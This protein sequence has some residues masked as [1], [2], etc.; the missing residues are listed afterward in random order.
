MGYWKVTIPYGSY[1]YVKN[2]IAMGSA[3]YASIGAGITITLDTARSYLGY[4]N[5]K[6][7]GSNDNTGIS[8]TLQA[9]AAVGHYVTVRHYG[10][11]PNAWD[12]SVDGA[13]FYT[14]ALLFIE[15]DWYVYGYYFAFGEC[16]G[17]VAL[18]IQKNGA[19]AFTW[20]IGHVQVEPKLTPTTP[21]T[22]DIKGFTPNGYKWLGTPNASASLRYSFERSGG[23]I[24]DLEDT[25]GFRVLYGVGSGMPPIQHNVQNTALLP[26]SMYQG[27]KVLPR[28]LDLVSGVEANQTLATL[29]ARKNF[30]N[31]VKPDKVYPEQP[32]VIRYMINAN[33]PIEIH[34]I[35]DSG[36]EFTM[37]SGRVDKPVPRFI[38]YDPFWYETHTEG[39]ELSRWQ[40]ISNCNYV[41]KKIEGVWSNIS[42]N[43]NG[44]VFALALG[45]D[46]CI[47]MAG[48]FTTA[49]G[50]PST[51][52]VKWDPVALALSSM[53][54]ISGGAVQA[55]CLFVAAN[56]DIYMGGNFTLAGGV[57]NTVYIAKWTGAAWTALSTGLSSWVNTV[58][59]GNDGTIYVG[60]NFLNA[61]GDADADYIAK[62]TG[63]AFAHVGAAAVTNGTVLA[64]AVAPN[65]DI[66]ATGGF[67]TIG[68]VACAH[69]AR[70]D[71]TTWYP[72]GTGLTG[73]GAT[74]Y[75]ITIAANG[76]VYVVGDF[77]TAGGVA[78]ANIAVWNGST[79]KPLGTGLNGVGYWVRFDKYGNLFCGGVFTSAGGVALADRMAVWNSSVWNHLDINLNGAPIVYAILPVDDDLY[80]GF[81]TSGD[82]YSS[83]TTNVSVA[84]TGSHSTYPRIGINRA[85]DGTSCLIKYI[86]NET[87]RQA[88]RLN[89]DLQKGETLILDLTPGEKSVISSQFGKVFRAILRGSDFGSFALQPG[90]NY[91]SVYMTEV[92]NPTMMCW[93]E[94]KTTHWAAE[95]AV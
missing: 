91:I 19:A 37:S 54:N 30:E 68:G 5:F 66:Y 20:Q 87:T 86:K 23:D 84:N 8:L 33:K 11:I 61:G 24:V 57:A 45:K 9:L 77:T 32:V 74:G 82:A 1:N 36:M 26:G 22:G 53:G 2:P 42:A 50:L 56:G 71:G 14:P 17:S 83:V 63:A 21:I 29:T 41:C 67:T 79:F 49:A 76:N 7:I 10:V 6:V 88:I 3:N 69:I 60:G 95:T 25:Y 51:G 46:N 43:F 55:F 27:H 65:G 13:N 34:G 64:M 72:L 70:F 58:V 48:G 73:G 47:Y 44:N 75:G 31:A 94:Y 78:C 39:K 28:V 90:T 92:G 12:W 40:L 35:Y 38:A 81:T 80:L 16:S 15:G 4:R 93:I 59:Q 62:W 18:R 89:Y 52:I 85:N